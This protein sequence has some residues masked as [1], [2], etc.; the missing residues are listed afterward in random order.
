MAENPEDL[1]VT[2]AELRR[3]LPALAEEL[4]IGGSGS[5]IEQVSGTVTLDASGDP[6]REFFTTGA[7]TF[8]ANGVDTPLGAYTAVV[9]RRTGSGSWGYQV[10]QDGWTTPTVAPDT[11]APV[12]GTLAVTV[13]DANAD[14]T[15]S[16]A[17][18]DRGGVTYAFSKDNGATWT[19]YQSGTT[20]SFAGLA[21]STSYVFR[22]KV[23]DGAGNETVGTAVT[24]ATVAPPPGWST[25]ATESFDG[26]S[27]A[28][29]VGT[30]TDTGGSTWTGTAGKILLDGSGSAVF[31]THASNS[32]AS[33][34]F[35]STTARR[36][37]TATYDVST[38]TVGGSTST[39]Y[40]GIHTDA[41]LNNSL[42]AQVN[43][44]G[45]LLFNDGAV[46]V[47]TYTGTTT[48]FPLTGTLTVEFDPAGKSGVVSVNGA[49]A[50]TFTGDGALTAYGVAL[51]LSGST[52]KV[53]DLI[54]EAW[55]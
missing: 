46:G 50:G 55:A 51:L 22:H 48:G 52:A 49:Q 15:V 14:L 5:G 39:V 30:T 37:V 8:K 24:K 1:I 40:V 16:G 53:S 12:A 9:W 31:D 43:S 10:V 21:A 26:A 6:I 18:D 32:R 38:H 7:T 13:T 17:S 4:G 11:T 25:I 33:F 44:K 27:G 28:D 54:V 42:T 23:K 41:S 47:W 2:D 34:A 45:E 19:A 3:Q 36:R 20:Y 35:A 29:L